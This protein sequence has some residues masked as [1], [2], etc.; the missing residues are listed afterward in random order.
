MLSV[1]SHEGSNLEARPEAPVSPL[2]VYLLENPVRENAAET[3]FV[4]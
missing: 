1:W 4:F 2:P 3:F